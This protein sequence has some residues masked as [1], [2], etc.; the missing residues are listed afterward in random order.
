MI[1][2]ACSD[3]TNVSHSDQNMLLLLLL[4]NLRLRSLLVT[5]S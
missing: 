2:Q 3:V 5:D 1:P 4:S